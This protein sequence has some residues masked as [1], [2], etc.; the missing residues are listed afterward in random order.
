MKTSTGPNLRS[1]RSA[2]QDAPV[3]PIVLKKGFLRSVSEQKITFVSAGAGWGK[4]AA[5]KRLLSRMP[6][7]T[8][9]GQNADPVSVSRKDK[10][11]LL[12]DLQD[13][14]PGAETRLQSILGQSR[15]DQHFV[16]LSR[17]PLPD[18][19]LSYREAGE[20]WEF[21]AEDLALD[22]FCLVRL[23]K[24]HGLDLSPSDLKYIRRETGGH[25]VWTRLLL[26]ALADGDGLCRRTADEA[27]RRFAAYLDRAVFSRWDS[28]TRSLMLRLS[29]AD[30]FDPGLAERLAGS[31]E[32]EA[33][34]WAIQRSYG[35][36]KW[37][38]NVWHIRDNILVRYL[39]AK[40]GSELPADELSSTHL[41]IA[42]WY[43]DKRNREGALRHYSAA[44]CRSGV[45]QI[46][47]DQ[48]RTAYGPAALYALR[49]YYHGLTREEV[50]T[51]PH[52][53][54]GMCVLCA[55]EYDRERSDGWYTVLREYA[56]GPG[57]Y[58][59]GGSVRGLCAFLDLVL[60]QRSLESVAK[61]LPAIA[62]QAAGGKIILPP[63]SASAG[64]PSLIRGC[65]DLSEWVL[66]GPDT[67]H[68]IGPER[69]LGRGGVA[70]RE[71]LRFEGG[72]ERDEDTADLALRFSGLQRKIRATGTSHMEFVL[73][74]LAARIFTGSGKTD[75]A[76]ALLEE[77][78]ARTAP[79][80][81]AALAPNISAMRC[82][83]GLLAEDP[84]A[85]EWF[86]KYAPD[87]RGC[88]LT[89]CYCLLTKA[90][91]YIKRRD[92]RSAMFLLGRLLDCFKLY[93]RH[94][95]GIEARILIAICLFRTGSGGWREQLTSALK[96]G[97]RYGYITVFS[98]EGAALLPIL[99]QY[100]PADI[101]SD[102][103]RRLNRAVTVQAGFYPNHLTPLDNPLL[104]LTDMEY[105]VLQLICQDLGNNE[106]G[107]RLGI[108]LPTVKT[109][110]HNIFAKLGVSTR[111]EAR[112]KA[113]R[114]QLFMG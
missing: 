107:Q 53:M 97:E 100:A 102:Y 11:I 87:D 29:L 46:L 47:T 21:R 41:T 5:A 89:A 81:D 42:R 61:A 24:E 83:I 82:R 17:G 113:V 48:A 105:H 14:P 16:I 74:A 10:L 31:G 101:D 67:L 56:G 19:L 68:D 93:D 94:L 104:A 112:H 7:R 85:D 80:E 72:F 27:G 95:D 75:R 84:Y 51:S 4:T 110:I 37:D 52:L 15:K 63:M 9:P 26:K 64:L 99:E 3:L 18:W 76:L 54:F 1:D 109:H 50:M 73:V 71:L 88:D 77:F 60:P 28:R 12:D 59:D 96:T 78:Q 13:L 40:A 108:R 91:C 2:P 69:L 43:A 45:V 44:G 79:D 33:L 55:M 8:I 90:R 106:I 103:W 34:L 70:L 23:A 6:H 49:D 111:S 35:C 32:A 65:R 25:P 58:G 38:G 57:L 92:H 30:T 22:P 62:G 114:L 66:A 20:L 98:A 86:E 36:F 39:Q